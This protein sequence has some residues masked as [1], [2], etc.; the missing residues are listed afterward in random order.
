[1]IRHCSHILLFLLVFFGI[2]R[3]VSGQEAS[4][5]HAPAEALEVSVLTFGPGQIYW[6]RF[7]HNAIVIHDPAS[8]E[9][10]SYN[11]GMFDFEEENFFFNFLRGRMFYQITAENPDDE[12]AYYGSEGRSVTRQDLRL[13]P[14]QA[15]ALKTYLD[16]NLQ[17]ENRRY[18]YDYFTSNCST[19]VRDALNEVLGGALKAQMISP[20]RGFS[21]RLL[22]DSL[23]T[24]EPLLMG[25][26]DIGL[27]PFSDQRLSYWKDSFVPMELMAHL[28]EMKTKDAQ[29]ELQ[30][31][32]IAEQLLVPARL[33]APPAL[34]PDLRWPFFGIGLGLAALMLLLSSRRES[35]LARR[36]FAAL[37]TA[38]SL[39]CALVGLVLLGL[40]GFTEHESAWRNENLLVFSP[41]CLLMLP[42]WWRS[43]RVT[44]EFSRLA[45][46]VSTVIAVF[47]AFALFSK[48][49]STFPQANLPWILLLL[50]THLVLARTVLMPSAESRS[51][52][53]GK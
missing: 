22:A 49:L 32:V 51:A 42:T 6:E 13:S 25:V 50:P 19:R 3:S 40:W 44:A 4:A 31:L 24:Q 33:P 21:Y 2:S 52:T 30:P 18:R 10:T 48:I 11:Y 46:R 23:T 36:S 28:R 8:G 35:A 1:M 38:F 37:A 26:I 5:A 27:G 53:G 15:E 34:P 7:G 43:A 12:I 16:T 17:P 41:L 9:T 20:S 14:S 47:A 39:V 29:G 45:R